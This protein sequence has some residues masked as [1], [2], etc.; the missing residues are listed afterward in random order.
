LGFIRREGVLQEGAMK[1][2]GGRKRNRKDSEEGVRERGE[3]R[4]GKVA[5]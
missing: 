3:G 4:R 5:K 2:R 1:H